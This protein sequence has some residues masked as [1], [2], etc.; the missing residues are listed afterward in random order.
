MAMEFIGNCATYHIKFDPY[1]HKNTCCL[2]FGISD[3]TVRW[4]YL[5]RFGYSA[6]ISVLVGYDYGS[7]ITPLLVIVYI[8]YVDRLC[9]L[10]DTNRYMQ[11]IWFFCGRRY[12]GTQ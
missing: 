1:L 9:R 11:D 2:Q 8:M 7:E 10:L 5:T 3:D 4:Q 12:L 6:S